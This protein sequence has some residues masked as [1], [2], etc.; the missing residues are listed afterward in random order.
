MGRACVE[1]RQ[2]VADALDARS[3]LVILGRSANEVKEP[4]CVM[5]ILGRQTVLDEDAYI[6]FGAA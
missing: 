1:V 3:L 6:A 5:G 2:K 4:I